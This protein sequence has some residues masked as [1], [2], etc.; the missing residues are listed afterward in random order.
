M[1]TT[2]AMLKPDC[3]E[4]KLTGKVI[5]FILD[6]DFEIQRLKKLHLS[7]RQAESFYYMHKGKDFYEPLIKFMTSGPVIP[8]VISR[9]DAIEKFREV[10][11]KTDPEKAASGTLREMYATD[12]RHNVVHGADS[13]ENATREIAFFFPKIDLIK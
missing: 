4:R 8:M 13:P 6:H 7:T 1:E 2:F 5:D 3:I 11:G 10:I 9:K 12:I